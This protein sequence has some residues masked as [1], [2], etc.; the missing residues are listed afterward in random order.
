MMEGVLQ[1]LFHMSYKLMCQLLNIKQKE[2]AKIT[3]NIITKG[4]QTYLPINVINVTS[5]T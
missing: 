3:V 5:I 4:L 2:N 1:I